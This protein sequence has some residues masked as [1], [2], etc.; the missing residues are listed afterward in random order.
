MKGKETWSAIR[1]VC[2][3]KHTQPFSLAVVLLCCWVWIIKNCITT[4]SCIF[5]VKAFSFKSVWFMH[6]SCVQCNRKDIMVYLFQASFY[7]DFDLE[8]TMN[9]EPTLNWVSYFFLCSGNSAPNN[10][11]NLTP[12][13]VQTQVFCWLLFWKCSILVINHYSFMF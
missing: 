7:I 13:P 6:G 10:I 8:D 9:E 3:L 5:T 11:F 1:K 12:P 4:S 2:L